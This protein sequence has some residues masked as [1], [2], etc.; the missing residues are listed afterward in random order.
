MDKIELLAHWGITFKTPREELSLYGSPNRTE[1]RFVFESA[2]G[3]IFIAE[4]YSLLKKSRQIKQNLFLEYLQQ[5]SVPGI[6]PFVRTKELAHGVEPDNIFWQIRPWI[7]ADPLDRNNFEKDP[8]YAELWSDFLIKFNNAVTHRPIPELPDPPFF[9][10]DFFPKLL[11]F[12]DQ[13]MPFLRDEMTKSIGKLDN[14]LEQEKNLPQ[15]P[16][17][18]DFHP[19]NILIKNNQ[20][21]AVID[22]EFTGFKCAGY[23][24]ALLLGCLGRD[25]PALLNGENIIFLQNQLYKNNYMPEI[26]WEHLTELMAAIRLGWLGEWI[27]LNE[28][29]LAQQ[30]LQYI[31]FL[32]DQ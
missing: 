26:S 23:D 22:W 4:G 19:G 11:N 24:P 9:F 8:V 30:E 5:N 10:A 25:D 32:L 20:I 29:V 16:A 31:N 12:A 7:E 1:K 2:D 6:H 21:A 27:D 14:F 15:S 3:E 13:K 17:H 18:G 28:P